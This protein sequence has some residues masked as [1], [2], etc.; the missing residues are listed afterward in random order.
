M[1]EIPTAKEFLAR[2]KK[3]QMPISEIMKGFAKRH[4]TA[5]LKEAK[6]RCDD[7]TNSE[8]LGEYVEKS[9]PLENIK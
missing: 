7:S 2:M 6:E 3:M 8:S 5:A 4:T 9:Y 1:E